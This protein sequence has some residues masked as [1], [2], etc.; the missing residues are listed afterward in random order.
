[1]LIPFLLATPAAPVRAD[2]DRDGDIDGTDAQG[3][4][5]GSLFRFWSNQDT[6]KGDYVGQDADTT[7]NAANLRVDGKLDLVNFFPVQ[8]DVSEF[9]QAWGNRATYELRAPL[10]GD[11]WHCAVLNSLTAEDVDA[12]QSE[13]QTVA[14]GGMFESATLTALGYAGL[15]LSDS[16]RADGTVMLAFE[17]AQSAQPYAG[18][19]LVVSL[20]GAEVHRYTLPTSVTSVDAM[21]RYLNLRGAESNSSFV[22]T[23][24]GSPPNLPDADN[25]F[26]T[27]NSVTLAQVAEVRD[28]VL[29]DGIPAQTFAA[30]ANPVTA[31]GATGNYNYQSEDATPNGWPKKSGDTKV[32]EH[33]DIKKVAYFYIYPFFEK[34]KNLR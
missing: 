34:I 17:A 5:G 19:E 30:G 22:P 31:F 18:P 28:R 26:H 6:D 21:Y 32:W 11:T 7:P 4:A 14:G 12:L 8:V 20:D 16:L 25:W 15:D 10:G 33:S 1:M 2:V 13:P 3:Q 9:R 29:A 23:I 27:T 24:P